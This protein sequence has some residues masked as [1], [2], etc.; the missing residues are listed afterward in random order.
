MR[1][2]DARNR[3]VSAT[4]KTQIEAGAP[5]RR[6]LL[7]ATGGLARAQFARSDIDLRNSWMEVAPATS[8]LWSVENG[9]WSAR[10]HDQ[11]H[12]DRLAIVSRLR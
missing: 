4:A 5:V 9:F 2:F 8:T 6:P 1:Y 11:Q 7:F 10:K 12:G 3:K